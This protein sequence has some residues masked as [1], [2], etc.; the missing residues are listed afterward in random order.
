MNTMTTIPVPEHLPL[1][2]S[3]PPGDPH[4]SSTNL[5]VSVH[6]PK[7]A[8]TVG[9][10]SREPRVLDVM[11]TGYPR[12]FVPRVVHQLAMRLLVGQ[13]SDTAFANDIGIHGDGEE[14]LA[15]LLNSAQ[16][17]RECRKVL[18]EWS[19]ER[20]TNTKAAHIGVYAVT[21]DGK[22]SPVQEADNPDG[23]EPTRETGEEDIILA[24]YPAELAL[25]AKSFWQHTARAALKDRI[26]T[27]QSSPAHNLHVAPSDVFLF[28]TGMSAIAAIATA[29]K[30]LRPP[31]PGFPGNPLLQS[32]DLTHLH[33][34]SRTHNFTL[35]VD[36]TVG[37]HA[38]T[39][40]GTHASTPVLRACD[41]VCTSLTKL[42]SGACNVMGGAVT[43]NPASG[44]SGG[45]R[46]VLEGGRG[47][48]EAA[49]FWEDVVVMEGNS[50][51]F[52]ARVDRAG[53]NA[54]VVVGLLRGRGA[55]VREV[56]YP[57][58]GPTQALYDAFRVE[59]GRYGF[60][61]SVRFWEK[62][63]AVAFYDALDVAKGP[64]LG[65][66]FTLCCAYTLLA[67]Y[68]ELEWAAGYGVVED[69]VRISVGLED[70][71][72]LEERVARALR[73][74]EGVTAVEDKGKP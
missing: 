41:A 27:G 28:P 36:D 46:G 3:L 65:T 50:R 19:K 5:G 61:V 35:V 60:L 52:G 22:V 42:F 54:E 7:W 64:S 39:P 72:W 8:D 71:A 6:L 47:E 74:A 40:V 63:Q 73:A 30:S 9:W 58:G 16:H 56:Y 45:L 38:S 33:Q 26:A 25:E 20:M 53:G 29:I 10:A 44:V 31:T 32:P 57:L 1:G 49:W 55:V 43:L 69:L 68:S 70:R 17:G 23:N 62:A 48:A 51:D 18:P 14:R 24:T 21:W 59:G 2:I 66:N 37:T 12:F 34:L 13:Q 4:V 11:K 15:T 67:H